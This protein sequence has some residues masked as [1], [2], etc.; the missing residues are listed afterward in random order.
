MRNEGRKRGRGRR[1]EGEE[2]GEVSRQGVGEG[3]RKGRSVR[4][5]EGEKD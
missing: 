1:R 5:C 2:G 3:Q 4:A